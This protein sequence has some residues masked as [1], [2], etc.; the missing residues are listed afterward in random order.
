[1]NVILHV[2]SPSSIPCPFNQVFQTIVGWIQHPELPGSG[3]GC[4][5]LEFMISSN[6]ISIPADFTLHDRKDLD[7]RYGT[8]FVVY[9]DAH[10]ILSKLWSMGGVTPKPKES[11]PTALTVFND[12]QSPNPSTCRSELCDT[13]WGWDLRVSSLSLDLYVSG[14]YA[15]SLEIKPTPSLADEALH[16]IQNLDKKVPRL[17]SILKDGCNRESYPVNAF[18]GDW[19]GFGYKLN[20]KK[21]PVSSFGYHGEVLEFVNSFHPS[22][23]ILDI[24]CGLRHAHLQNVINCEIYAYPSTDVLCSGES[25][26]FGDET[27]DGVMSLAVLEHVS[28]PFVNADEIKRV[29]KPGGRLLLKI[30]FLQAEHGYPFH[31]FNATREGARE[32]FKGLAVV[33]QWLDSADHPINTLN[34]IVNIYA[35]GISEQNLEGFLNL[36]L[37]DVSMLADPTCIFPDKNAY[38][39]FVDSRLP[40]LIAW[41][42]TTIFRKPHG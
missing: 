9:L 27:V 34:Q 37:R 5:V 13:S 41:G 30:P 8:G 10:S 19:A 20:Q 21:D 36:R 31:Y 11:L 42:T 16:S 2:D 25:L 18:A 3:P 23:T 7:S 29:L 14:S 28:N 12:T 40:W 38:L 15:Y 26:P 17:R 33:R 22:S 6:G 35:S 1:M 32:L 24:G 4:Y 39:T